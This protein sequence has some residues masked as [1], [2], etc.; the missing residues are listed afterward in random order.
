MSQQ[1]NLTEEE[2]QEDLT[3]VVL[4]INELVENPKIVKKLKKEDNW[5]MK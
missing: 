1:E 5:W 2:I 4:D 3:L